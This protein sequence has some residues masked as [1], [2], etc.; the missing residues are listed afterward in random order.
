MS[1]IWCPAVLDPPFSPSARSSYASAGGL[2]LLVCD[3]PD[4][5]SDH[6]T[7]SSWLRDDQLNIYPSDGDTG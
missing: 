6:V 7:V 2:A 1:V 3:V 5:V 4:Y